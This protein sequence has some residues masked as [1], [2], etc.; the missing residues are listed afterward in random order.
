MLIAD[1][2]IAAILIVVVAWLLIRAVAI[3]Y[4]KYAGGAVV[5]C[6]ET[7]EKAGVRIDTAHVVLTSFGRKADLRLKEC[8]RW[9]EREHCGQDC[10]S[11]V[12]ERPESCMVHRMLTSWYENKSCTFCSH[13]L[14]N[15]DWIEHAPCVLLPDGKTAEWPQIELERVPE[16]LEKGKP[17]CWTCHITENFRSEHPDLVIERKR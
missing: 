5:V 9:P 16:L 14:S 6:P 2:I 10:L 7:K 12:Q 15:V 17:V 8:S 4:K 3:P 11:Q 1:Y 13:P